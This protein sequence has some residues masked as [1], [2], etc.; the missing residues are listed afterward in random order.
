MQPFDS[1]D[2]LEQAKALDPAVKKLR[3][4]V[5]RKV[6]PQS[7]RDVL[8]GVWLGHPLHPVLVQVPVGAWSS[9]AVLDL[10]PG[11]GKASSVLIGTGLATAGPAAVAGFTDWSELNTP[12]QRVGMVHA[13]A[14]ITGVL[15]YSASLVARA[16]GN[17]GVGKAL[18][19]AGLG[20]VAFGG[21][22]GGHLSYSQ[23]SG[24]NRIDHVPYVTPSGWTAV[25][26]IADLPEGRPVRR[27]LG[28]VPLFVL[29]RGTSYSVLTDNCSH[30]SGPLHEGQLTTSKAG[31]DCIVCPWHGSTFRLDDGGV[32]HGPATN[33]QLVFD[34]RVVDDQL[35]VRLD[36][37]A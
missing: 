33:Q 23:A 19:F 27:M 5:R 6:Q 9:A 21:V 12:Q 16:R 22:L 15:L 4:L 28:E 29:R 25:G 32:E 34:T 14:N 18:G 11:M 26:P 7:L 13:S 10:I 3:K 8:H 17:S 20:T 2:R 37:S 30:L 24:A 31:A 35:E 1:I 36:Q